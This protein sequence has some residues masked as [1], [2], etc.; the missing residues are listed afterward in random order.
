MFSRDFIAGW[1]DM[2]FNAHMRNTAY[3]DRAADVRLAF[4]AEHGFPASEFARLRLGP[5]VMKDEVE[6]FRE[7]GLLEPFSVAFE[8]AGLSADGSRFILRNTALRADGK[9]LA[10]VTSTGGWLDLEARKLVVPPPALLEVLRQVDRA[11]DYAE[12]ASSVAGGA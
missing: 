9:R 1:S 5:V 6:Y 3:L 12:L 4:F 2:D 11:P 8:L 10:R 7:V